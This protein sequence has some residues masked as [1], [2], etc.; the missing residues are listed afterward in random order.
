MHQLCDLYGIEK[1][2]T[3]SYH[4][5]RNAQNE[6]YNQSIVY[7]VAKLVDRKTFDWDLQL[8][9]AFAADNATDDATGFTRNRLIFGREMPHELARMLPPAPDD[10]TYE[11]WDL[12]VQKLEQNQRIAYNATRQ[13]LRKAAKVYKNSTAEN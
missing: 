1:T 8:P 11:N 7:I 2:R 4:P 9:T 6:H 10:T 13:A 12:Y 5:Q 3:T